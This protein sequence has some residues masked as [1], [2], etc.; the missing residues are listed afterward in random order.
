MHLRISYD[1]TAGDRRHDI[2][3]FEGCFPKIRHYYANHFH[4]WVIHKSGPLLVNHDNHIAI[5]TSI[6]SNTSS[7]V[8]ILALTE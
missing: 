2:L 8:S 3:P 4:H 5:Y 6:P 1:S 7:V